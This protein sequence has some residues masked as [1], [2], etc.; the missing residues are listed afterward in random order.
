M[1]FHVEDKNVKKLQKIVGDSIPLATIAFNNI[2]VIGDSA[3]VAPHNTA[4]YYEQYDR[5]KI[6]M[7]QTLESRPHFYSI[8]VTINKRNDLASERELG[9]ET[10]AFFVRT[11][12]PVV[13]IQMTNRKLK[14]IDAEKYYSKFM[15]Y[16][17]SHPEVTKVDY[18]TVQ[19]Y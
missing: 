11:E 9:F 5:L 6:N 19:Y 4:Y 1:L 10:R 3:V 15:L 14:D 18:E 2:I 17:A 13:I 8:L 7:W 16:L 12:I